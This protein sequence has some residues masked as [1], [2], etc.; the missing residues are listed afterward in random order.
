MQKEPLV[1][2]AKSDRFISAVG[3]ILFQAE[4]IS[5]ARHLALIAIKRAILHDPFKDTRAR[6]EEIAHSTIDTIN[7]IV[8]SDIKPP[9]VII[10]PSK[11]SLGY[12]FFSLPD[13]IFINPNTDADG[14]SVTVAHETVHYA[15]NKLGNPAFSPKITLNPFL[16]SIE[17]GVAVF[18]SEYLV[19]K[20][21]NQA[22]GALI[23]HVD[24]N[25]DSIKSSICLYDAID[26]DLSS[27]TG[28]P[29]TLLELIRSDTVQFGQLA[30]Y[31]F[32]SSAINLILAANNFNTPDTV[33]ELL[34]KTNS[35]LF[36]TA[37][38]SVMR[39]GS[40]E[41]KTKLSALSELMDKLYLAVEQYFDKNAV[42]IALQSAGN[43]AS[44]ASAKRN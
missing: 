40:Q 34:K 37:I 6:A 11:K 36:F 9:I 16:S 14:L 13:A 26:A 31:V 35:D 41:L 8:S 24:D 18:V 20:D 10:N 2:N 17:E 3:N 43:A 33:A 39:D 38:E 25:Y 22:R 1:F 29:E 27:G 21:Q 15:R 44:I 42:A 30:Q 7:R 28:H 32:G 12:Y 4:R 23:R 5:A 19:S